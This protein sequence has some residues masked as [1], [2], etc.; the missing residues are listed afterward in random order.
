MKL[1]IPAAPTGLLHVGQAR[2]AL[3]AW[4]TARRDGGQ[5]TLVLEDADPAHARPEHD[6]AVRHDLD[7]LGLDWDV[8]VRQSERAGRYASAAER[9]R[10]A[11]RIYACFESEDELRAKR[12]RRQRRGESTVYDRAML[13]M[14]AAQREEAEAG[15]KRPYWRFMLND[16]TVQWDDLVLGRQQVKLTAHS[17]P[18]VLRADG[19]PLPIFAALVDELDLR[20]THLVRGAEMATATGLQLDILAALGGR[21]GALR[22]AHL[23]GL[24]E[25]A[26]PRA[27]RP[28][29]LRS[30]RGDGIEPAALAGYLARLGTEDPPVAEPAALLASRFELVRV[31]Q[32]PPRFDVEALLALNRRALASLPFEAVRDRLPP[33]ATPAFWIAVRGSLDLL[34]EARGWWEVVGGSIVPPLLEDEAGTLRQALAALPEE[35][36]DA[37]TW[38]GWT[39]GLGNDAE[40]MLRLALTGEDHGPALDTLLPLIGRA[41]VAE[42]LRLASA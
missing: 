4:L 18:V 11:G 5:V 10:R 15:G 38:S 19:A 1:R 39:T 36:W 8:V 17:D 30:L 28:P 22:V 33:A 3:A 20:S 7:W 31:G 37:A 27:K 29:A 13:K 16:G 25:E 35:P 32:A 42:R 6:E 26:G 23:P 41:R 9:L 21:P 12:D 34:R 14:T 24:A 2:L 40:P